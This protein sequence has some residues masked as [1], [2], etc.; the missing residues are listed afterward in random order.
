MLYRDYIKRPLLGG[1]FWFGR[2]GFDYYF[3]KRLKP[4][5]SFVGLWVIEEVIWLVEISEWI[6][7]LDL[8]GRCTYE[9]VWIIESTY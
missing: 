2:F 3:S 1:G 5:T 4:P 6:F 8:F 9:W 7:R